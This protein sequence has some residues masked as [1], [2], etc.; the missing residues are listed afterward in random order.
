M[1]TGL[2]MPVYVSIQVNNWFGNKRIRFKKNVGKGQEDANINMY[3]MKAAAEDQMGGALMPPPKIE[4]PD[5]DQ[6]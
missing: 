1:S 3:S 4:S 6:G 2:T 5:S